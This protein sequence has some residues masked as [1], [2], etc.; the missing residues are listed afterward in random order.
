L[1][2]NA[3]FAENRNYRTGES[4]IP[5]NKRLM[6]MEADTIPPGRLGAIHSGVGPTENLLLRAFMIEK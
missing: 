1:A 2:A 5:H 3:D 6:L 4:A